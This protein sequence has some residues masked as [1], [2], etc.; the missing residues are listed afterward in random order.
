MKKEICHI[1]LEEQI[2]NI[3][4][5]LKK[6][7]PT[8]AYI[9]NECWLEL[10]DNEINKCPICKKEINEDIIIRRNNNDILNENKYIRFLKIIL[11]Y[12]LLSILGYSLTLLTM[13]INSNR[14]FKSIFNDLFNKGIIELIIITFYMIFMGYIIMFG[15]YIIIY[16]FKKIFI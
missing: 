12:I 9:C 10:I 5:T 8:K 7:C 3:N 4:K 6:C 15:I 16:I 1:C 2:F 13:Y 11:N 14:T